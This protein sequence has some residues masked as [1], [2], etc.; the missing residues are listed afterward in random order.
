MLNLN[1]AWQIYRENYKM[2]ETGELYTAK[3]LYGHEIEERH[4]EL[5]KR[6]EK[7]VMENSAQLICPKMDSCNYIVENLRMSNFSVP[8]SHGYVT[9]ICEKYPKACELNLENNQK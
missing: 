8:E 5:L 2:T 4:N 6:L 1:M 3:S 7:V 9:L